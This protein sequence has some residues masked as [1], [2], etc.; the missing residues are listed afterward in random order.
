MEIFPFAGWAGTA[1]HVYNLISWLERNGHHVELIT[2]DL[3]ISERFESVCNV[4][5][6]SL[7]KD[8]ISARWI[9]YLV[10]VIKDNKIDIIHAHGGKDTWMALVAST[11]AGRG[12]VVATRHDKNRQVK[13][14]LL[15][16]WFYKKLGASI[17]V[18]KN[19]QEKFLQDNPFIAENKAPV[20]YNGI[21]VNEFNH[22]GQDTTL[23]EFKRNSLGLTNGHCLLGFFGRIHPQ[24]GLDVAIES[25]GILIR[26][27]PQLHLA[28][29]GDVDDI[30]F[31]NELKAKI[32][33]MDLAE[34][35]TF[36]GFQKDVSTWMN[37]IDILVFPSVGP[38]SFGLVLCEALAAAKP[39][40]TTITGGQKEI[41]D[42]G[43]NGLWVKT[44]SS[45][46]LALK[47]EKLIN[48]KQLCHQL[49]ENGKK[50]A[51]ERFSLE[52]MGLNTEKIFFDL[53][54][55]K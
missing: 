14:D 18:S 41:I 38:E 46:D 13:K 39:V 3:P 35:V 15:H 31:L 44:G 40:I 21:D 1:Q 43:V 52:N 34:N 47:I 23:K 2:R 6:L 45:Q 54:S 4:H 20:V 8:A 50:V 42:D 9:P 30:N 49:G 32:L 33:T 26:K 22:K 17:C 27:Y 11:I 28:I 51:Q 10:K 29:F 48:D 19:L 5:R 37:V 36:H 7:T 24:K 25:L 12:V 55:S 16:Q 53:V